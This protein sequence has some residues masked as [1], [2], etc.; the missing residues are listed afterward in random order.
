MKNYQELKKELN[1]ERKWIV[2]RNCFWI[3]LKQKKNIDKI[4]Q[5]EIQLVE[6]EYANN[7]IKLYSELEELIKFQVIDKL[8][9]EIK[10]ELLG[11][12]DGVFEMIVKLSVGDQF[13]QTHIRFRSF[14]D[15]E[16]YINA[17]DEGYEAEDAIFKGFFYKI[18]T[19]QFNLVN[20][21]QY[22]IG[23][24][25]KHE[26]IEYRGNNCYTPTKVYCFVK[27]N[28]F[29]N[30]E[31]YKPQYLDFIRKE[32]RRSNILNMARSQPFCRASIF[33]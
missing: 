3:E 19:L 26:I 11:N 6:I 23:C 7:P 2:K 5:L 14:T 25:F 31:D 33:N 32:K 10:N 27:C 24:D 4:K 18:N 17:I 8:L 16:N 29:L 12:Y 1:E 13:R 15:Y 28:K 9:H 21:S 30:D 20:R 22:G